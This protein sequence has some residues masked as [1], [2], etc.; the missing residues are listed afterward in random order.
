[1]IGAHALPGQQQYP[2]TFEGAVSEAGLP[3]Q[4]AHPM[5]GAVGE[6]C[7][8]QFVEQFLDTMNKTK[9][10]DHF[11]KL[12]HVTIKNKWVIYTKLHT[13]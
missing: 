11:S 13:K 2:V 4:P 8:G 10:G 7:G 1:M 3:E 6:A 9:D 12:K 5:V